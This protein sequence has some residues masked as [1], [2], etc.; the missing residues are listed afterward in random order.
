M[1]VVING[2]TARVQ[3]IVGAQTY[4]GAT[5]INTGVLAVT[6]L[7]DGGS[8]SGLG[9]SSSAA[10]NRARAGIHQGAGIEDEVAGGR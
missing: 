7:A 5:V 2:T 10:G 3:G 9:A 8:A 6:R 4:T 1:N